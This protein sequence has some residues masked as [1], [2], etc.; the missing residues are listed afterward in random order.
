MFVFWRILAFAALAV[1]LAIV[2]EQTAAKASAGLRASGAA[3]LSPDPAASASLEA[4]LRAAERLYEAAIQ[5]DMMNIQRYVNETDQRLRALPM[6][7][8]ASAEGVEALARSVARMKRAVASVSGPARD[9]QTQAAEIRLAADALAH[10]DK[11]MWHM[12][13]DIVMDDIARIEQA[14]AGGGNLAAARAGLKDLEGHYGL[15]R[16]AAL[17]HAEPFV[18]ERTDS[19]LRYAQ[20]VLRAPQQPNADLL[21]GVVPSLRDAFAALFPVSRTAESAAMVPAPGPGWG[22][23]AVLA[24]IIVTVLA[25]AG[26]LRYKQWQ[27]VTPR[28]NLPPERHEHRL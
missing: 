22:W 8:I 25:W 18:V 19:V 6:Q 26:W 12:Y 20:R 17:L 7:Q 14:L 1:I 9:W 3:Q 23:P 24:S 13:R 5:G 2:P 27:L 11:P 16:T 10:P 15:I 21:Q 4:F 28:G